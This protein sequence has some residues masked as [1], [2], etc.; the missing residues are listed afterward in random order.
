MYQSLQELLS[1]RFSKLDLIV[2]VISKSLERRKAESN[3]RAQHHHEGGN[4]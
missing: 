2:R 4:A 3:S 1:M